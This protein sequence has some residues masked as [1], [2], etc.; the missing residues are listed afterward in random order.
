MKPSHNSSSNKKSKKHPNQKQLK[1]IW[2]SEQMIWKG[3][4]NLIYDYDDLNLRDNNANEAT[5]GFLVGLLGLVFYFLITN[6]YIYLAITV[7]I[8]VFLLVLIPSFFKS[9]KVKHTAYGFFE[10]GVIFKLWR[11]GDVRFHCVS[12]KD[13]ERINC[14]AHQRGKGVIQLISQKDFFFKTYSF[15]IGKNHVYPTLEMIDNALE[16]S[17]QIEQLKRLRKSALKEE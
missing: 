8:G 1:E 5:K 10:E 7:F 16:I 3:K 4:P 2:N 12:F 11:W 13:I 9:Q 17:K 6:D 15:E 14:I